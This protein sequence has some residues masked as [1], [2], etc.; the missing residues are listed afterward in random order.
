MSVYFPFRTQEFAGW[1]D[2]IQTEHVWCKIIWVFDC[3]TESHLCP[4]IAFHQWPPLKVVIVCVLLFVLQ[5]NQRL[6]AIQGESPLHLNQSEINRSFS[7]CYLNWRADFFLAFLCMF[8]SHLCPFNELFLVLLM[9]LLIKG[10]LFPYAFH[11]PSAIVAEGNFV[12]SCSLPHT[13]LLGFLNC[14]G[15][16]EAISW[17]F[18]K[19]LKSIN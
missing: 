3:R 4:Q 2:S 10:L 19:W 6:K 1:G 14:G 16:L 15:T 18:S 8:S 7:L 12:L 11:L 13:E 17:H 9:L 5:Q